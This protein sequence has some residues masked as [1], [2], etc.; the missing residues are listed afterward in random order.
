MGTESLAIEDEYYGTFISK[1]MIDKVVTDR[2]IET[3]NKPKKRK[4]RAHRNR[5]EEHQRHIEKISRKMS[6][7]FWSR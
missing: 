6:N 4:A 5:D 2:S 1:S 7:G 3:N